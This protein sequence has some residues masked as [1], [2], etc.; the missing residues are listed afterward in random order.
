MFLDIVVRIA[1]I[2]NNL[3]RPAESGITGLQVPLQL[4]STEIVGNGIIWA[5]IMSRVQKALKIYEKG[6]CIPV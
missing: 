5:D 1:R 6:V 2:P 4:R 3:G